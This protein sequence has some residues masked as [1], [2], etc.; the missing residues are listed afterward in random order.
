MM[1]KLDFKVVMLGLAMALSIDV[2]ANDVNPFTLSIAKA[3]DAKKLVVSLKDMQA[4]NVKCTI[5]NEEGLIVYSGNI[6]MDIEK[7]Y[8]RY[9]LSGLESGKYTMTVDDLM[10]VE[11]IAFQVTDKDILFD[12]NE[13]E[14]IYKPVVW[15]NEDKT[16]DFN[17]LSFG[18]KVN[19]EIMDGQDV[20]YSEVIK[21][22]NSASRVFNL[23]KVKPGDYTMI[24]SY[25]GE[26]F[27][28]YITV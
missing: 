13:S 18:A 23:K 12:N 26:T 27:Y 21:G 22:E 3:I 1:K 24:V 8:K 15:V 7:V 9:D 6:N 4:S 28:R 5:S 20:I 16:V 2:F 11:K 17:L 14:I 25:N 10:K 19:V